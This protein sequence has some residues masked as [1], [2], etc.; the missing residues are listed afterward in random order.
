M[1]ILANWRWIA[2]L[3]VVLVVVGVA[4]GLLA[5]RP[6]M[7]APG[8][9]GMDATLVRIHPNLNDAMPLP[10]YGTSTDTAQVHHLYDL[11]RGLQPIPDGAISSCPV[12]F[13][14]SYRLT[15]RT[16]SGVLLTATI[17]PA[18]CQFLSVGNRG[19]YTTDACWSTLENTF[20]V[21]DEELQDLPPGM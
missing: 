18:G 10:F 4:V 1:R 14:V 9:S 2:P 16:A 6:A 7:G 19:Y 11:V 8:T 13:G 3:F 12:D 21:T 20:N 5:F 17:D 15:F